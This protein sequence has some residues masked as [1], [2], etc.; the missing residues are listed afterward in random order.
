MKERGLQSYRTPRCAGQYSGA[1]AVLYSRFQ[2]VNICWM[3]TEKIS[4]LHKFESKV[5]EIMQE[6]W[7]AQTVYLM[8]IRIN[9]S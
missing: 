4:L 1:S 5:H 7:L 8:C 6:S 2:R 9:L 3:K